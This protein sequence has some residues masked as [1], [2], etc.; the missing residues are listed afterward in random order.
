MRNQAPFTI[1]TI[2]LKAILFLYNLLSV[3]YIYA[4]GKS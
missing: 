1:L 4:F 3:D 2:H